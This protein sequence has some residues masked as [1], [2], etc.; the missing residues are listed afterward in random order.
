MKQNYF[1][2]NI[3]NGVMGNKQFWNTV[4]PF[5]V[6]KGFLHNE[7]IAL[8]ISDKTVAD[9]NELVKEFNK[10]YINIV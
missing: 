7:D 3:S 2:E 5:L 10:H 4:K 6:S 1:S 9:S 8:H